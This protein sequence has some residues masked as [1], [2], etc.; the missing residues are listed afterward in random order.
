MSGGLISLM[1]TTVLIGGPVV[2]PVAPDLLSDAARSGLEADAAR[3]S[4]GPAL[5]DRRARAEAIQQEIGRARMARYGVT[6]REALM[7]DT[8]VRVFEPA[9]GAA[10][11]V[12]LMNLHGG[13]FTVDAGSMTETAPLAALTGR[14]VVAVRY[15]LAPEHPFPAAVDDAASVYREIS[16]TYPDARIVLFGTSAGAT[17]AAEL[18]A[19][20]RRDGEPMP[21]ALG[22]FS[23]TADLA[24]GG[25]SL[26]M[27]GDRSAAAAVL[28]AYLGAR[29]AQDVEASPQRGNLAGWPPTLCLSSS[30]DL[31]LSSTAA[32]C[33]ALD[34]AGVSARLVV[35]DALPHAFWAYVDAPETDA[36]FRTMAR[37]LSLSELP[38]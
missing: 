24:G 8:P 38:R 15:R 4:A 11:G 7:G 3:P 5:R 31:L 37:H 1:L 12:I 36:A 19:R 14:Q 16:S 13:G 22:F 26:D 32:F 9:A 35:F 29:S 20:L 17:L 25:D 21:A 23:G 27:F 10:P 6:M 34:E 30:R 28:G 33:R 2:P 18:V